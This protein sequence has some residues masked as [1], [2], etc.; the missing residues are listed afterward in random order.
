MFKLAKSMF[1]YDNF[2]AKNPENSSNSE[3]SCQSNPENIALV[4]K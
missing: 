4:C 2:E 1:F 3:F